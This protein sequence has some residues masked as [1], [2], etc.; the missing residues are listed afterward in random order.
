MSSISLTKG[1]GVSLFLIKMANVGDS[2][3]SAITNVGQLRISEFI[4]ELSSV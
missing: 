4:V 1:A 2:E 3:Q